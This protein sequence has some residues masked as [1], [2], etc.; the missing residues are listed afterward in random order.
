MSVR[1][2]LWAVSGARRVQKEGRIMVVDVRQRNIRVSFVQAFQCAMDC[3][4]PRA[5][6]PRLLRN[7]RQ[8]RMSKIHHCFRVVQYIG[9]LR[10]FHAYI[11][12]HGDHPGLEACKK[13]LHRFYRVWPV[14]RDAVPRL[15][16]VSQKPLGKRCR[17]TIQLLIRDALVF[18]DYGG[19][20]PDSLRP[21]IQKIF[22]INFSTRLSM[23]V[24]IAETLHGGITAPPPRNSLEEIQ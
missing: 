23:W 16:A 14:K 10:R 21:S 12:W 9:D 3:A 1:Y 6:F 4:Q 11:H 7:R 15:A 5:T 13:E 22:P 17:R 20:F 8:I 19:L 24:Q 18:E 2:A